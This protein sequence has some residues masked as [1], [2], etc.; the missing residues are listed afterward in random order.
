MRMSTLFAHSVIREVISVR[1]LNGCFVVLFLNLHD[2]V[3]SDSAVVHMF[4]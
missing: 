3:C 2:M 4:W 1:K